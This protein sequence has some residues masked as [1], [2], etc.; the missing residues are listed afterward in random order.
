MNKQLDTLIDQFVAARTI[1]ENAQIGP[2][3]DK[4]NGRMEAI[5]H[6]AEKLGL[7][8]QLTKTLGY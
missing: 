5:V 6:K 7:L 3:T 2:R 1:A 8:P 4:A